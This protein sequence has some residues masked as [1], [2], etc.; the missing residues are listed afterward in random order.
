MEGKNDVNRGT[1]KMN[2]KISNTLSNQLN[3]PPI[4][5]YRQYTLLTEWEEEEAGKLF[6]QDVRTRKERAALIKK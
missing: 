2:Q 4:L 3:G 5:S 6:L 1:E